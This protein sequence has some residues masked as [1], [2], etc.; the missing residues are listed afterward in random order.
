MS[1][2]ES[3]DVKEKG[4]YQREAICLLRDVWPADIAHTLEALGGIQVKNRQGWKIAFAFG[5]EADLIVRVVDI[6]SWEMDLEL[7]TFERW[8]IPLKVALG[9]EPAVVLLASATAEAGGRLRGF[10]VQLLERHNGIVQDD[11]SSHT[12]T[13]TD[14]VAS[15][16]HDGILRETPRKYR[17]R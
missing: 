5:S 14:I 10:A 8:W 12:W 4:P 7:T 2:C 15:K 13:L 6:Y 3:S 9:S 16:Q 1:H 11:R 17:A